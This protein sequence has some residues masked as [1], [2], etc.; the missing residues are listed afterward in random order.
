MNQ[1]C[2]A[3]R[4]IAKKSVTFPFFMVICDTKKEKQEKNPGND[5]VSRV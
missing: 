3:T 5:L 2:L 4:F 1:L